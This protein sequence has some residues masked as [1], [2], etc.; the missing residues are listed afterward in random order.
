MV[1]RALSD[2]A[3]V[4]GERFQIAEHVGSP[5][6]LDSLDDFFKGFEP[7]YSKA[8]WASPTFA[9]LLP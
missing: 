7:Q 2:V 3:D 1:I 4:T 9:E 6:I 5:W 8:P